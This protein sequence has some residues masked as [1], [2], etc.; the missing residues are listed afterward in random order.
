MPYGEGD[1]GD[2]CSPDKV[3]GGGHVL[4]EI[5]MTIAMSGEKGFW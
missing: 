2:I 3:Q 4:H 5:Y 1:D